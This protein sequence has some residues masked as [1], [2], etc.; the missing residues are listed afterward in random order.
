MVPGQTVAFLSPLY[1]PLS[2]TL[3]HRAPSLFPR[4][5]SFP[6][7]YLRRLFRQTPADTADGVHSHSSLLFLD[8]T[9]ASV[10]WS[11]ETCQLVFELWQ[12]CLLKKSWNNKKVS[13][14]ADFNTICCNEMFA[15]YCSHTTSVNLGTSGN[16][17]RGRLGFKSCVNHPSSKIPTIQHVCKLEMRDT[18]W[19]FIPIISDIYHDNASSSGVMTKAASV[20]NTIL[21]KER[22]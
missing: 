21:F 4:S 18:D 5:L 20:S 16:D 7:F 8:P 11:L 3:C 19:K 15:N 14:E 1:A 12:T 22:Q 10:C 6:F 9:S 17:C 13:S 2:F